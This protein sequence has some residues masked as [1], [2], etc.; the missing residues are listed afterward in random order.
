MDKMLTFRQFV[1]SLRALEID[2]DRAVIAHVSLSAF[3]QVNGGAETVLGALLTVFETLIMPTFT[4]KTMVT[5]EV[6]PPDNALDYGSDRDRNRLAE[7]FHPQ[8]PADPLMGVVAEA[9]RNHPR[10]QRSMHPILSF[11]GVGA[12]SILQVQTLDEP[13]APIRGMFEQ[14]GWVLLMGVDHTVN[15]SIHFAEAL[16]GRKRFVRWALTPAGIVECPGFPGCS[17]G[18]QALAADLQGVTRSVTLGEGQIQAVP[19]TQ[20]VQ[21]ARDKIADDPLALLCDRPHCARCQAVRKEVT[22]GR[23]E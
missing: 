23:T 18:F 13:L 3:G 14:Q 10:A 7:F 9:L 11:S 20:L 6:G 5:P 19:L 16:A 15:T 12:E 8:M 2:R 4:Y 21:I 22:S 17:L 1:T